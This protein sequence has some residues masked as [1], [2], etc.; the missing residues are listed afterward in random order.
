[1]FVPPATIKCWI[2][3]VILCFRVIGSICFWHFAHLLGLIDW[4]YKDR[5]VIVACENV[6][7]NFCSKLKY[8]ALGNQEIQPGMWNLP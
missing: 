3:L 2:W 1:M 5:A 4:I 8:V 7:E 6:V